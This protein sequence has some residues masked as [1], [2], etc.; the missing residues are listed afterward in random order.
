MPDRIAFFDFDGTLTT[1][2]T[3]LKF[4]RF[5]KGN[6]RFCLGFILN[7]PWLIAYRL[8]LISNQK[9]KERILTWFFRKYPLASFQQQCDEFCATTLPY[10]LRPKGLKEIDR[11]QK[12]GFTVAIIS[13]SPVNWIDGW[14]RPLGIEVLATRLETTLPPASQPLNAPA[15]SNY[16]EF[17]TIKPNPQNTT[18]HT[19]PP[20]PPRLTGRISGLNCHGQEKV[21][22]IKESFPLDQ[23]QEIYAYGDTSGDKPMLDLAT[24]RFYKPF[25]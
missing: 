1:S 17:A 14:A 2:D 8:K 13:A 3:L 7:S 12:K 20:A 15:N 19:P 18:P 10:L 4:I 11:L 25:R 9:A 24:H 21:R 16:G 6:F 23:Y 22:R 5:S